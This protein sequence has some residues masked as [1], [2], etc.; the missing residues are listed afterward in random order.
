MSC[1]WDQ[2]GSS[3]T[4]FWKK[5]FCVLWSFAF[6]SI[7]EVWCCEESFPGTTAI[8]WLFVVSVI[9]VRDRTNVRR[10]NTW[11]TWWGRA[12]DSAG[13]NPRICA[14]TE[15]LF[16]WTLNIWQRFS[17]KS[18]HCCTEYVP[19]SH[20]R[21]KR[22][23]CWDTRLLS[24]THLQQWQQRMISGKLFQL[25]LQFDGNNSVWVVLQQNLYFLCVLCLHRL[26]EGTPRG[27]S[28]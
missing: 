23:G 1:H 27:W 4:A 2:S 12:S 16:F 17:S 26:H 13:Y 21:Q 19:G 6:W 3:A 15:R 18:S 11:G 28:V 7:R 9:D 14:A 10:Q 25:G 22:G 8:S 5:I 24:G 20:V